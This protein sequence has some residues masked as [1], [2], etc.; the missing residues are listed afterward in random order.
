MTRLT[1]LRQCLTR[2]FATV[3]FAGGLCV[4]LPAH[5]ASS[6]VEGSIRGFGTGEPTKSPGLRINRDQKQ[7][8]QRAATDRARPDN[9]PLEGSRWASP[10]DIWIMIN[11]DSE[12]SFGIEPLPTYQDIA[13][14][15]INRRASRLFSAQPIELVIADYENTQRMYNAM[16][17]YLDTFADTIETVEFM[18]MMQELQ[19][20]EAEVWHKYVMVAIAQIQNENFGPAQ[21]VIRQWF[22]DHEV[23]IRPYT[24]GTVDILIDGTPQLIEGQGGEARSPTWDEFVDILRRNYDR[25]HIA[26]Q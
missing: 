18:K 25:R 20:L 11:T 5:K 10:L 12:L 26:A 7:G 6:Q 2:I 3:V 4:A 13:A 24:D 9:G 19:E 23:E 8:V 15:Q 22:P 16:Y 1:S 17:K 21:E 14:A